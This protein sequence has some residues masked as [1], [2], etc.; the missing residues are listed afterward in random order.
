MAIAP[1]LPCNPEAMAQKAIAVS[2]GPLIADSLHVRAVKPSGATTRDAALAICARH[3]WQQWLEP[4]FQQQVIARMAAA[5]KAAGREFG[6][7]PA[8][9]G[10]LARPEHGNR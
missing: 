2:D 3:N 4:A 1:I 9:F 5:A 6:S 7:G 8:G 10:M